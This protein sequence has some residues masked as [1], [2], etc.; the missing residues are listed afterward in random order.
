MKFLNPWG[1]LGGLLLPI[2]V[3]LHLKR[4]QVVEEQVPSLA[5]W[6]EVIRELEGTKRKK[7]KKSLLLLIQLALGILLVLACAEPAIFSS[8]KGEEVTFALDCSLAMKAREGEETHFQQ[9]KEEIEKFMESLAEDTRINIVLLKNESE[10]YGEKLSKNK[11][12][13]ALQKISCTNEVLN[14][15]F[16]SQVLQT[17]PG[18]VIIVSNKDLQL[19][20]K[21]IQVGK[22]FANLG[23]VAANYDYYSGIV[24]CRIKNYSN[25]PKEAVISLA[26]HQEKRD[27]QSF[28]V[29][30]GAETDITLQSGKDAGLLQL[31]IEN[32]DALAEDNTFI[33][34][35]GE[36]YQQKIL[37][38]GDNFF[39]HS[40]LA[41]N[42][43]FQVETREAWDD[44][45]LGYD[46]Y[47]INKKIGVEKLPPDV[48]ALMTNVP[49]QLMADRK[50]GVYPLQM[51]EGSWAKHVK[52]KEA[53]IED[54]ILLKK[55]EGD[56]V[57]VEVEG[58]PL[59]LY[60]V[61]DKQCIVYSSLDLSNSNLVMLPDFPILL[62]NILED[63]FMNN[64]LN[65]GPGSTIYPWKG[66]SLE[67]VGPKGQKTSLE[68]LPVTLDEVGLYQLKE[69]ETVVKH[70]VVN[71]PATLISDME[72]SK[73][74]EAVKQDTGPV[75]FDLQNIMLIIVLIL[76]VAEWEV[77]KLDL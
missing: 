19:G 37:L 18:E 43:K 26:D 61:K 66:K 38:V 15:E 2:I 67:L 65:Y 30:G 42:P 46:I 36:G 31:K 75:I 34:P 49:A 50:K 44:Q 48:C 28:K 10:L 7:I 68:E 52:L 32:Q 33:L 6:D 16:A 76:L 73:Q 8:L 12:R 55:E 17:L 59:M 57:I 63:F 69:G 29:Q 3:L 5:F 53:F 4:R 51:T 11:V 21:V 14:V 9:A 41:C 71:P 62:D 20:D 40:A 70:M 22:S 56:Q 35:L 23:I 77:A 58:K 54:P 72:N 13:Q 47:V 45:C 24:L 1:L 74:S 27:I 39:L 25:N 64:N 60:R